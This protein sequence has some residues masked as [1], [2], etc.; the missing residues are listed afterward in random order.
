MRGKEWGVD[1]SGIF[2]DLYGNIDNNHEIARNG[3]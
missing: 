2:M 3:K 1:F